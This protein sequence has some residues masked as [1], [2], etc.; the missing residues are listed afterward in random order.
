VSTFLGFNR[1]EYPGDSV[2]MALRAEAH[3]AW[4]GFYLAPAPSHVNTG[5][6]QFR[7]HEGVAV[8]AER[9][10]HTERLDLEA[11]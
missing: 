10:A 8:R 6:M 5:W 3:I 1:S 4:T 11:R 2:L 9:Q 7:H